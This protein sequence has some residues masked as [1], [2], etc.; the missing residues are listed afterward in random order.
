MAAL[1]GLDDV[2]VVA[3]P[4]GHP[5]HSPWRTHRLCLASMPANATHLLV[6]QDDAI[7]QPD[8]LP[9][10]EQ[11]LADH[12][13]QI[14]CLFVPGFPREKRLM[15]LAAEAGAR[16]MQFRPSGWLPL[17]AVVYPREVVAALLA[18][19]ANP[20]VRGADDAIVARFCRVRRLSPMVLVPCAVD[21][22]E[23]VPRVGYAVRR[24]LH[25]RAALL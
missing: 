2:Q 15:G 18:W 13:E 10:L 21:H 23:S 7:P 14:I 6:L 5:P 24:G 11:A 1:E 19:T 12:P 16:Y 9:R 22:D 3:D 20:R 17:V 8:F 25:R 4:G